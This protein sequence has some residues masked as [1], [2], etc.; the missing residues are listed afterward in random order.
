M[1]VFF[2][3]DKSVLRSD[4]QQIVRE[5]SDRAK[6]ENKTVLMVTGHADTSGTN[7]YNLALSKRRAETVK[8][9]L[10]RLGIP[11]TEIRVAFKGEAEPLV[12]TGDGVREPQNRRVE[13]VYGP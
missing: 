6:R 3:F 10:I 8:R 13:I 9:E 1:L 12:Q 7:E 11:A 4:A 5:A 2:D